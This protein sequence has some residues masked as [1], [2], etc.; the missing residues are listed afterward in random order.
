MCTCVACATCWVCCG[1]C[2]RCCCCWPRACG[3]PA[4]VPT[5]FPIQFAPSP[6]RETVGRW[7]EARAA[8]RPP[9]RP[10]G[11]LVRISRATPPRRERKTDPGSPRRAWPAATDERP[12]RKSYA[13]ET[14]ASDCRIAAFGLLRRHNHG[15]VRFCTKGVP[16]FCEPLRLWHQPPLTRPPR[17]LRRRSLKAARQGNGRTRIGKPP[18]R[19]PSRSVPLA[20]PGQ[21]RPCRAGPGLSH[22]PRA[23]QQCSSGCRS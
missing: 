21:T 10:I 13:S 23:H 6:A 2:W 3:T 18:K 12:S 22:R 19:M 17:N 8:P 11:I 20:G 5:H 9:H 16:P 7:R 1:C 4:S 14:S 15:S